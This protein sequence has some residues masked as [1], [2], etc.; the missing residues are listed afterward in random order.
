MQ[1]AA[2]LP[3]PWARRER[4][5]L[6]TACTSAIAHPTSALEAKRP[7]RVAHVSQLHALSCV[8]TSSAP[9]GQQQ[10]RALRSGTF[11]SRRVT[12]RSGDA[13]KGLPPH[14]RHLHRLGCPPS[15]KSSAV[16]HRSHVFQGAQLFRTL[17]QVGWSG[18]C[19]LSTHAC[20]TRVQAG[21]LV[22]SPADTGRSHRAHTLLTCPPS[23]WSILKP[24]FGRWLPSQSILSRESVRS[25]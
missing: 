17:S 16:A 25:G 24:S 2:V 7:S 21:P 10:R 20:G 5:H 14:A 19:R 18:P 11:C 1:S 23:A 12:A 8:R 15:H 3:P 22:E 6:S 4:S 9:H 13:V